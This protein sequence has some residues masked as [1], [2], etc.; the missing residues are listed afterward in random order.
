MA[1]MTPTPMAR[2]RAFLCGVDAMAAEAPE[3][4]SAPRDLSRILVLLARRSGGESLR[5]MTHR[6]SERQA[7][8]DCDVVLVPQTTVELVILLYPGCSIRAQGVVEEAEARG[9]GCTGRLRFE[10]GVAERAMLRS[11]LGKASG[12][13]AA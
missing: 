2:L 13:Q 11:F 12:P 3:E 6:M 4:S 8:F 7:C 10:V 9:P 5:L 1:R